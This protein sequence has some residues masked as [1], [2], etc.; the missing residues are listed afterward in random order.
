ME[1]KPKAEKGGLD[2]ERW[3]PLENFYIQKTFYPGG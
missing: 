1:K 3:S 2:M